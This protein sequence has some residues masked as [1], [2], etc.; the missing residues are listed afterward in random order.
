VGLVGA[1][2]FTRVMEGLLFGVEP[3]DPLT[4]SAVAALLAAIALVASWIPA[5]R[6]S[7]TDPAEVLRVE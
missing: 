5:W 2:L 7:R 4:F 3:T 6:A 1:L